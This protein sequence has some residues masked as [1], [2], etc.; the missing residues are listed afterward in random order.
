MQCVLF[1]GNTFLR[2]SN[3]IA[4]AA[5]RAAQL[6]GHSGEAELVAYSS[7]PSQQSQTPSLTF[8]DVMSMPLNSAFTQ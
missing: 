7:D 8:E 6:F 3:R 4:S 2:P 1:D 5:A